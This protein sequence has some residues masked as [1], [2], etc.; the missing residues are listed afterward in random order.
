[1]DGTDAWAEGRREGREESAA[2]IGRLRALLIR[3]HEYCNHDDRYLESDLC[4]ETR[5]ALNEQPMVGEHR[6]DYTM[7]TQEE[8]NAPDP[9][10]DLL[11]NSR[12]IEQKEPTTEELNR[13]KAQALADAR[14]RERREKN[15]S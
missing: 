11:K 7:P 9:A 13:A 2:E 8:I 4:A 5:A 1:M 10:D 15:R 6:V 14:E 12:P 3:F